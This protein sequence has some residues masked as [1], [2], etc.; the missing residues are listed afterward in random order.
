MPKGSENLQQLAQAK[1]D[2]DVIVTALRQLKAGPE[3]DIDVL[4]GRLPDEA[5]TGHDAVFILESPRDDFYN[6]T[7]LGV[8]GVRHAA[9]A[10][11]TKKPPTIDILDTGKQLE[12]RSLGGAIQGLMERMGMPAVIVG[13]TNLPEKV[14]RPRSILRAAGATAIDPEVLTPVA[15]L[16]DV[17]LDPRQ[18]QAA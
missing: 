8:I 13:D 1:P 10:D 18:L 15:E 9:N 12:E 5:E 11:E 7:R 16:D 3:P 14:L 17:A 4:P 2:G 6:A